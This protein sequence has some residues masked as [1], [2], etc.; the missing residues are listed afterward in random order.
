MTHWPNVRDKAG[1]LCRLMEEFAGGA[2]MSLGGDLSRCNFADEMVLGR[3]EVG[4]LKR[5]P[6][7]PRQ[8]FVVLRLEPQTVAPLFDQVMATGLSRRFFTSRSSVRV[9]CNWA[10]TTTS[11][12]SASSRVLESVQRCFPS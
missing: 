2:S 1:F 9:F 8:D 3:E 10:P 12:P 11:I 4:L 5:N 7:Y 6:L